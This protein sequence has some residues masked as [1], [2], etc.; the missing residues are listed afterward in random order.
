MK[1]PAIAIFDIGKTNKKILLF[2]KALEVVYQHEQFMEET[3]DEDGFPCDDIDRLESWII[4]TMNSLLSDDR[5]SIA[6][7]N[8]STYGAS[9]AYLDH[10]G[11]R[12]GPVYNYLK[13]M[14]EDVLLGFYEPWGGIDEFS[15]ATASPAMGM[16]NSGLQI[17]WLKKNRPDVFSQVAEILHFPQ[18]VSY[19]LTGKAVSEYTSIGC[20]TAMWDF[21]NHCYHPWLAREGIR[22]PDPIANDTVYAIA[23]AARKN[24]S[25]D[26]GY[27]NGGGTHFNPHRVSQ[28]FA[29][30]GIHDSSASL[31]PY[32]R[33]SVEPFILISTGTW[34]IFMN[35]FNEEPLTAGQ[36]RKDTLCYMSVNQKQVKS[37]RLFMG[38]IHE[39][40]AKCISKH[41][42]IEENHYK[43]LRYDQNILAKLD[44]SPYGK[45]IFFTQ[46]MPSDHT[47]HTV[48]YN[49][50]DSFQEAYHQLMI[51]LTRLSLDTLA[52][53][54]PANDQSKAVYI[55]GGFARNDLFVK[56]LKNWLP[57]KKVFTSE[58]D[59][60]T[61]LGAAMTIYE[62]VFGQALPEVNL[63]LR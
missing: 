28:L 30:T 50:F 2:N 13:P 38:H 47:D 54:T 12:L 3:V 52:L 15:R 34:G 43:K 10:S 22:L 14:P 20:H 46:G 51:D 40:N 33:G 29:G 60:A 59:N 1:I 55:S 8:F 4:E 18:Y 61:A 37:A 57:G 56:L 39:V 62:K 45:R 21:D 41:F 27:D 11:R 36:L 58:I 17:F 26:I 23:P 9:L 63:G 19:L 25:R 5:F 31:V 7:V 53:A 44:A 42:N 32:L 6:G 24:A 48:S 35:P 16:L 49:Q